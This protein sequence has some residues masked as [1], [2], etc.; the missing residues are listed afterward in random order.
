MSKMADVFLY[1]FDILETK[2]LIKKLIT[3]IKATLKVLIDSL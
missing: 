3:Y 2:H 1:F